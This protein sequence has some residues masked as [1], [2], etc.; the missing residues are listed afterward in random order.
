MNIEQVRQSEDFSLY[1]YK[2][3]YIIKKGI[4]KCQKCKNLYDE[5]SEVAILRCGYTCHIS[6]LQDIVTEVS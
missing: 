3:E 2:S 6:C 1:R 4:L 5:M